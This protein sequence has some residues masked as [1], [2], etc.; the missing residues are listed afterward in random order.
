MVHYHTHGGTG[1]GKPSGI[2]WVVIDTTGRET[3]RSVTTGCGFESRE[4]R[5]LAVI[6]PEDLAAFLQW[7]FYL[8]MP[9]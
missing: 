1:R 4:E 7:G 8:S 6:H 3:R 2:G 5:V 9:L